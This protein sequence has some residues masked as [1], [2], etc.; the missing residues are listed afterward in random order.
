MRGF[1]SALFA[2]VAA[3]SISSHALTVTKKIPYYGDGFYSALDKGS[4]DAGL[5]TE[6]RKVLESRHQVIV[7]G[8]D[9]IGSS[10]TVDQKVCYEQHNV[11]YSTARKILLGQL[12]LKKNGSQ[13]ELTDVY[14]EA[15][16]TSGVGPGVVPSDKVF[17]VEHTWPQSRFNR[18]LNRDTQK[19]DFHHLFPSDSKINGIRG[20]HEFADVD[21]PD[22]NLKC[23]QDKIGTVTGASGEFFE[24]PVRHKGNVARALFYFSVRYHLP[25]SKV[26]ESALRRW[27]KMDPPDSFEQQRNDEIF[28][29]QGTRN[30]FVDYPELAEEIADF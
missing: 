24:P 12:H 2:I 7:G 10:C 13:Y 18:Q 25:I 29:I 8:A 15:T 4:K 9:V 16:L 17:N 19:T 27:N 3:F 30:P 21:H 11:D 28:K 1:A 20:N 6:L 26:E 23:S 22:Q 14:C 5:I